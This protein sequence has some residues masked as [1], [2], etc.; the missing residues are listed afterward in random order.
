MILII[1]ILS[2]ITIIIDLRRMQDRNF[3]K[4]FY[5]I[6]GI[7]L[8]KHEIKN[9]FTGASYLLVSSII[10]IAFFPKDIAFLAL[11]FLAIGDTFA[12]IVGISLGKREIPKTKKSIE[13][14]LAC[15]VSTFIFAICFQAH[16]IVA[17]LGAVTTM[18]IELSNLPVDDNVRIPLASG[19]I[20]TLVK[21]FIF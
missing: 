4:V 14:S 12:A 18:L 9:N 2:L 20:M 7:V 16:I 1:G 15:F 8:R 3:K 13:G 10:S 11:S 17:F 6:F 5:R 21:L 19:I